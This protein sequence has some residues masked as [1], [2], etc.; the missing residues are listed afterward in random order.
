MRI[1][2]EIEHPILKITIFKMDTTLSV[3]IEAFGLEQIYKFKSGSLIESS[4]QIKKIL[5]EKFL[6]ESLNELV[7][8]NKRINDSI[9]E[10][11]DTESQFIFPEII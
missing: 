4:D 7:I 1:I 6:N 9:R 3:K 2:D 11:F 8:M 5:D 10:N